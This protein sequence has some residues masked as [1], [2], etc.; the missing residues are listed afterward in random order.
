MQ[1]DPFVNM[2]YTV[3]RMRG[4]AVA[5]AVV[6]GFFHR[7]QDRMRGGG[8]DAYVAVAHG[9]LAH[10]ERCEPVALHERTMVLIA[11]GF[12]ADHTER[13]GYGSGLSRWAWRH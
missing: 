4:G 2:M 11:F 1:H 9:S 3:I 5:A 8:H 13:S 10:G 7:P 12:L 6:F